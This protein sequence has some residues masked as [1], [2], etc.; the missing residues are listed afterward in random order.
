MAGLADRPRCGRPR[1]GRRLLTGRIA[2]MLGRPG[3]WTPPR[4]RRYLG[5]PYSVIVLDQLP[6]GLTRR[7]GIDGEIELA[8]VHVFAIRIM[9]PGGGLIARQIAV[10]SYA[11]IVPG[12]ARIIC[13]VPWIAVQTSSFIG[14]NISKCP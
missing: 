1:L 2:A 11:E 14:S 12:A 10:I 6:A 3:P 4:T 7:V 9:L 5:L 8:Y 13:S